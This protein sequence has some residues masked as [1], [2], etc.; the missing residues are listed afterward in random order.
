[1]SNIENYLESYGDHQQDQSNDFGMASENFNLNSFS[2]ENKP[3][4][5]KVT[6]HIGSGIGNTIIEESKMIDN[7]IL[8][9]KI[10]DNKIED[11]KKLIEE[12]NQNSSKKKKSKV[13]I[14]KIVLK[15]IQKVHKCVHK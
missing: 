6:S 12:I 1:M 4:G 10:V 11:N 9:N 14:L 2:E 3:V 8:D 15:K 7:K 5:E 13:L